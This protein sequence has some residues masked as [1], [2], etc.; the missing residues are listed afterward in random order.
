VYSV[1]LDEDSD[2]ERLIAKGRLFEAHRRLAEHTTRNW[3]AV[4][5]G[6]AT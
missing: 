5:C 4:A 3:S 6:R 1:V 2:G